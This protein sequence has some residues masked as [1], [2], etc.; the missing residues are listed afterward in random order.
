MSIQKR[1]HPI[2]IL[3]I[4]ALV[5][6]GVLLL[7]LI[8]KKPKP[9]IT[10]YL[11][12]ESTGVPF[13]Y[14]NE[15]ENRLIR[16]SDTL[17]R[18]TQVIDLEQ[19]YTE[20]GIEYAVIELDGTSYYIMQSALVD[21]LDDVIQEKNVF[22]RTPVTVYENETGP[23]IASYAEKGECLEILGFDRMNSDGSI[24]KYHVSF[25][26]NTG[27]DVV[28]WVYGKYMA[29]TEEDALQVNTQYYEIHKD[30]KYNVM[31]LY[32]GEATSL[33]WFPVEKPTLASGPC[34]EHASAMYICIPAIEQIDDYIALAKANGVNAM[35]IDIKDG[36]LAYP[37]EEIKDLCPTA[38]SRTYFKS[39]EFYKEAVQK[40]LD[41]GMYCI[42]RIVAFK[43]PFF[44]WDHPDSAIIS[45]MASE[46][47]PSAFSR[48]CWYYNIVLASAAAKYCGFQEIQFDYVR[49][50]E[51]SYS[52][53]K[54]GE[55]NFQNRYQ[56]EKA[57]AIQNFCYYASDT[58]HEAGVY[59][60]I[61][62]FGECVNSYV[63]AYGQYFPAL[64][65]V[66]DAISAMPYPDHY[67]REEDTWTDPYDIMY[68]WGRKA[69][70]RQSEI[71]TPAIA[72]TWVAAYDVPFWNPTVSCDAYYIG[73]QVQGLVDAGIDGGFITWNVE[74]KFSKYE[75]LAPAW[76]KTY[77]SV[78]E[79]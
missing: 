60:S 46:D 63:T 65:N 66:V 55:A 15:E 49:F 69:Y 40:C 44:A 45:S 5:V 26:D 7:L 50:P 23:E 47:W 58:L 76:N 72:R 52:M 19:T 17:K 38:Y 8:P 67:G 53:S 24:N 16:S 2:L 74:S 56:E 30:R 20:N 32:G 71:P 27:K 1:I 43:D 78:Y 68:G 42:G 18:G 62:V 73:R 35:V 59:L 29:A 37:C 33:D 11:A 4:A 28:G 41:A 61:D 3:V 51:E 21:D 70:T 12:S 57:Q 77:T 14:R 13:Y 79:N 9:V 39:A 10:R 34:L 6:A 22:V 48:D 54:D 36:S 64:S 31:E 25:T 75:E